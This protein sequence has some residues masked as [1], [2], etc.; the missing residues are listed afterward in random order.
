MKLLRSTRVRRATELH[1]QGTRVRSTTLH[2]MGLAVA[3][4]SIGMLVSAVVELASTNRDTGAL[5]WS[6]ALALVT[7]LTLYRS[8]EPGSARSR[9]V[10]AAVGWTW[11][12]VTIFGAV[13]YV[14]GGR[15]A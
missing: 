6:G 9:D 3:S 1:S 4:V 10:F 13:P 5:L 15:F 14:L 2:V 8:T 7:G 11:L 12:M